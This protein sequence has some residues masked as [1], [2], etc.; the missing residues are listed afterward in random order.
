MSRN[1]HAGRLREMAE[2]ASAMATAYSETAPH[3]SVGYERNSDALTFGAD[4]L[5]RVEVL[6]RELAEARKDSARLDAQGCFE[7]SL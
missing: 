6:E 3:V 4:A 1:D 5:E 7:D 2:Y